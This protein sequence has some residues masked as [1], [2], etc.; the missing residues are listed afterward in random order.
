[1]GKEPLRILV[2]TCGSSEA[3]ANKVNNRW[4][5]EFHPRKIGIVTNPNESKRIE[6]I[7]SF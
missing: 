6:I 2:L 5:W 7:A 3:Q 4:R 1:M